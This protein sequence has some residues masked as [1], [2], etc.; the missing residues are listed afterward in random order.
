MEIIVISSLDSISSAVIKISAIVTSYE[1][2]C[3]TLRS[4]P[5]SAYLEF[6]H[7]PAIKIGYTFILDT[8]RK[9]RIPSGIYID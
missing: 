9:Y 4:L 8:H 3:A 6:E 1:I 2:V 7:Q 5:R